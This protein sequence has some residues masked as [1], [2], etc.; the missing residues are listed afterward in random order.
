MLTILAIY[1]VLIN[2][3]AFAA[4]GMDKRKAKRNEWRTPE[5][6]L[7]LLA[8]VGGSVGAYAGM[9]FFRHKTKHL[10]FTIGVPVIF[11]VQVVLAVIIWR[12]CA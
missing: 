10:K 7:L 5:S 8:A 2:I 3:A 11:I 12:A 6:V 1:L 4:Y 9:Q